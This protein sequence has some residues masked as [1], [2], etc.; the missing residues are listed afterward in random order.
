MTD[1]R[2]CKG[3]PTIQRLTSGSK[4]ITNGNRWLTVYIYIYIC[5]VCEGSVVVEYDVIMWRPCNC[6][7]W[8]SVWW[9]ELKKNLEIGLWNLMWKLSIKI[10]VLYTQCLYLGSFKHGDDAQRWGYTSVHVK[11]VGYNPKRLTCTDVYLVTTAF[12][13]IEHN[14]NNNNNRTYA[15]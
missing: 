13:N 4:R 7:I 3:R 10:S 12:T 14:N 9:C 6:I 8:H 11:L 15:I 1:A 2:T 5:D